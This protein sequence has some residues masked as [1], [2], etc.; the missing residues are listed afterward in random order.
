MEQLHALGALKSTEGVELT[1][2]GKNM[3][4]FPLDPRFSKLLLSAPDF[5][6]L[7]EVLFKTYII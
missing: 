3:A 2:L 1:Q 4:K 6:C 5:D 7:E